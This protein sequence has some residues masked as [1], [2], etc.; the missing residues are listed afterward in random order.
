LAEAFSEQIVSS[1]RFCLP[2]GML[3]APTLTRALRERGGLVDEWVLYDT[4]P[5]ESDLTGAR[6]RY[7]QEGAHWIVFTSSS[8]V[9]NWHALQLQPL[10]GAPC[11]KVIS[12]GPVT[13]CT[14]QNLGYELAA[15][16]P[17]ST[18]D[19]LLETILGL[20][21]ELDHARHR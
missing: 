5:E 9:E 20:S 21:I 12:L 2:Q 11:P 16:A 19:S 18:L 3:A 14:V 10:P 17:V 8:T 6:A 4:Q 13:S 1:V 15:Q 7:V